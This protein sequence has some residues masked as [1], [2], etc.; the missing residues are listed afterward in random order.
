MTELNIKGHLISIDIDL[1]DRATFTFW[2]CP[3]YGRGLDICKQLV[4]D[5]SFC[6]GTGG[7]RGDCPALGLDPPEP[8]GICD[9]NGWLTWRTWFRWRKHQFKWRVTDD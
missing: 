4:P 5:C 3:P 6:N 2:Y 9:G 8:C 7:F 1:W